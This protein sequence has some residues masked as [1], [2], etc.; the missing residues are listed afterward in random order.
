MA[1]HT[2]TIQKISPVTHDVNAYFLKRPDNFEFEPGQATDVCIELPDWKDEQR[3]FTFT[4]LPDSDQLE[5]VIKSYTDHK[6]V[7]NKL[8]DL[9]PGNALTIG[10][11]W[12]AISYNGPGVFLAGGAGITPFIAI[13]RNLYKQGKIAGNRLIFGNKSQKDIILKAE[14]EKML[15]NNFRNI[16]S[17]EKTDGFDHGFI[18]KEYLE[19]QI[20]SFDQHF[21]VCGPEPFNDS[22]I[23]ALNELGAKTER[24]VFEK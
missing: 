13:L 9:K 22:V 6:G 19:E 11:A 5:F 16:L 8:L 12:G 1:S 4:N 23:K 14:F 15:G 7:T 10:D 24:V 18:T 17:E 21:Y 20:D 3:P 2:L